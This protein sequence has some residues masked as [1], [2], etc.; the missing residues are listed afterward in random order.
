MSSY[1]IDYSGGTKNFDKETGIH[2]GVIPINDLH[3]FSWDSFEADYGPPTCPKCGTEVTAYED[4]PEGVG[5][6]Y[7]AY[8]HSCNDYFCEG[9][10][11][12]LGSDYV[13]GDQPVGWTLDDGEY[14][15]FVDG[16]NDVMILK[17]SY[18]TYCQFCSPCAP[19]AGH[20]GNPCSADSGAP[21]TYCFGADWFDDDKVPYD[22]YSVKTGE[23]LYKA[24]GEEEEQ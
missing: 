14:Q 20:L 3:E 15:A 9:C 23:L 11:L 10:K 18:F 5:D 7:E 17:S 1:G 22:V 24:Q 4:M 13:F 16:Y 2:Y 12:V 21:K 8:Q 6:E 19:G